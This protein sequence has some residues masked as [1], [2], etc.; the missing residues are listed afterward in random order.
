MPALEGHG[1]VGR[2]HDDPEPWWPVG[3]RGPDETPNVLPVTSPTAGNDQH[4]YHAVSDTHRSRPVELPVT[5]T[6][7]GRAEPIRNT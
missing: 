1:H 3:A 7:G 2:V 6:N 4:D 5:T